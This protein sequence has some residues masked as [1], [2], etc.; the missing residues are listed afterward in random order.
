MRHSQPRFGICLPFIAIISILFIDSL[1]ASEKIVVGYRDF[2]YPKNTG[3]N[4]KPTGE[5]PE[6]KLWFADGTWWGIL[7]SGAELVD[8]ELTGG[9]YTINRF[10]RTTQTW[11]DTLTVVDAR[12]KARVDVGWDGTHLYVASHVY[13]GTGE[14]VGA[15]DPKKPL[16]CERGLLSRFTYNDGTDSYT[17]DAG[18]PVEVTL[19]KSE[20]LVLAKDTTGRLWVTYVEC[21]SLCDTERPV[22]QVM[23]NHSL[24]G[25]DGK[26]DDSK[27]ATPFVLPGAKANT[28]S[29]DDIASIIA[30]DGHVGIMWSR[31]TFN[32]S[33]IN[34]HLASV[35]MNFAVHDDG[36]APSAW[37]SSSI[38]T[39]SGD[40]HINLK[41]YDGYVYAAFKTDKDSKLIQ[42]L[43]C[44]TRPSAC[45]KKS[46]WK[47]YP[48]FKTRDNDGNSP[49]ADLKALSHP[50]PSRPIVLID[51]GNRELYVFAMLEMCSPCAT[52]ETK[53]EYRAIHYKKTS[54]DAIRFDLKD[55]GLPF[56]QSSTELLINDPTSTKQ[57]LNST[58]GLVVLASDEEAFYYFHNDLDLAVKPQ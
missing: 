34:E 33:L 31:Q 40:D 26:P 36:A 49:Q 45:R 17:L 21:A 9:A 48:V 7:W 29:K 1:S 28:L 30:Y 8:G 35:T 18:F 42:L 55:P 38:Y 10:D 47:H 15:C 19:G 16:K 39:A 58:T 3:S 22:S 56:I 51:T 57:N 37:T 54:L 43:A 52:V 25:A 6:S 4:S 32:S 50:D 20:T 53:V 5:K 24:D 41:A 23:V 11:T 12:P 2:A 27:W 13:K 46:D 14:A 44:E